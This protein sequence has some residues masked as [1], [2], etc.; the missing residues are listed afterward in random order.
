MTPLD[1][2]LETFSPAEAAKMSGLSVVNQRDY[3][4]KGFLPSHEGR[5]RF[6]VYDIAVMRALIDFIADPS[7]IL[8]VVEEYSSIAAD[9]AMCHEDG[10]AA[11]WAALVDAGYGSDPA[12]RSTIAC[13]V[14][15]D[16]AGAPPTKDL[17]YWLKGYGAGLT[18]DVA[19]LFKGDAPYDPAVAMVVSFERIG[20]QIRKAAP[21]P[22]LNV[23][24]ANAT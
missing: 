7:S 4:R 1:F 8:E 21:R 5:A 13:N 2:T 20:A 11:D 12:D 19:S 24:V 17:F 6:T 14:V 10:I 15:A 23:T 3:R 22:L 9:W 18:D 16:F